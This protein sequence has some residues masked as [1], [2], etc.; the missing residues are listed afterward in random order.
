MALTGEP[1][2]RPDDPDRL[3]AARHLRAA[4]EAVLLALVAL[5]PWPFAS[6]DPLFEFALTAGVVVLAALWAAHASLTRRFTFRIDVLSAT[7]SGLVAVSALQ[8]VPLPESGVRA[9]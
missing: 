1:S 5:A 6:N 7:L 4:G 2:A 9:L 8:L 3:P